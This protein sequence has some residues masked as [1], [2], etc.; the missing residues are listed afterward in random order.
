MERYLGESVPKLGFGLMRLPKLENG[1]Y[2]VDQ[3][4]AMV[5]KFMAAG[6]KY[7]DTA[8]V[9]DG[10]GS[11]KMAKECLVDRYPRD[12]FYLATKVMVG[13]GIDSAEK[14]KSELM[15]S[16]ERTGAGYFDFYLM[17]GIRA[18]RYKDYESFG[19][20][21]YI[22]E[23]KEEGLIRHIGFSFHDKPDVLDMIL[24]EHPEI[25]FVQLQINYAD[26]ENVSVQS[27]GCLE[28][29]KKHGVGVV[30]MEPVKGGTLANPPEAVADLLKAANPDASLA[31]WAI[32]FVASQDNIITVLS[33]MST[34]EQ[35]ED[36]L[37]YMEHF[38]PLSEDEQATIKKAQEILDSIY[39]IPC[40]GCRYCV[41]GCPMQINIPGIFSA[42]NTQ[43]LWGQ[44]ERGQGNYDR[45]TRD[46]GKAQDCLQCGQCEAECPQH[47]GIIELLAECSSV[48]DK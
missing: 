43:L 7:Y 11:E 26:W 29:A 5:D 8:W 42:R 12:S 46:G 33:G 41:A 9:Y 3:I 16:L 1:E 34:L 35:M 38:Q 20:F 32:R 25:E 36:N 14:A 19:I 39:T 13:M 2:D 28:V 21:D 22:R 27:R 48:F 40:T 45:Q 4:K 15:E 30:V 17:H 47:L 31:S 18:T 23:K 37:S 44:I 10:G 24:T 6:M